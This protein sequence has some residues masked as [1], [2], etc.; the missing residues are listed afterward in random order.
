MAI[1]WQKIIGTTRYE[2]RS[3]GA[4]RRLY[5][6]GILHTQ[7]NPNKVLTGSVWDLLSLPAFFFDTPPRRVL[8]LGVGGG[9]VIRQLQHFFPDIHIDAIELNP[10]HIQLGK[11]YFGLGGKQLHLH[12]DDA[13]RWLHEYEGERFDLIID[14]L[15]AEVAGQPQRAV[16]LDGGWF[17][18]LI[19]QLAPRGALVANCTDAGELRACAW[20][21]HKSLRRPIKSAFRLMHPRCENAVGVFLKFPAHSSVLLGRHSGQLQY[22]IRKLLTPAT[23]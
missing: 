9:A 12:L 15:F 5:E 3:A 14:D 20:F 16:A 18:T 17:K 8:V 6:N 4:T 7:Y 1:L 11:K 19:K 10:L 23:A 2:V 13:V 22:T 21:S